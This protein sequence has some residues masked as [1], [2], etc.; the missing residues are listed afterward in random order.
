MGNILNIRTTTIIRQVSKQSK[1]QPYQSQLEEDQSTA[2]RSEI[3]W[4][5]K[6]FAMHIKILKHKSKN[7]LISKEIERIQILKQ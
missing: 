7:H 4:L 5:I 2:A 3:K 6:R 1:S